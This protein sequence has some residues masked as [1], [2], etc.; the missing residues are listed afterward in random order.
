MALVAI[1]VLVVAAALA[2]HWRLRPFDGMG[3][4]RRFPML[5]VGVLG[6]LALG[7]L[8][9]SYLRHQEETRLSAVAS[10][11]A[12]T[13]ASVHCQS[14][15]QTFFEVGGELGFV[16]YG[17][18]GV[19]EHQ[20]FI[21]RGPCQELTRYLHSDRQ[22]P[23]PDEVIAV[24][25]LTHESMHMAGIT[26]EAEAECAAVQ[27]DA[28]TAEALGADPVAAHALARIYWITDYPLMPDNYRSTGCA[29]GG[30]LDEHLP[31]PP[32]APPTS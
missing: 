26:D 7:A 15:G 2:A 22:H 10:R 8:V 23:T 29:A 11:L 5:S 9:P 14:F 12:G 19:P 3:R 20:T 24:H 17:A 28:V 21:K 25:V 31:D 18:D 13:D 32:W 27:R 6:L 4:T 16:R 30:S 1:A